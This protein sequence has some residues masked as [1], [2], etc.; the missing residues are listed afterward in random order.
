DLS[1]NNL[2]DIDPNAFRGLKKLRT[3][4]QSVEWRSNAS[5][6]LLNFLQNG[7]IGL[8]MTAGSILVAYLVTVDHEL[9]VEDYVLF[10]TYIL[11]LYFPLNFFG[12][13]YRTIQKSFI[14]ME[15]M[16]DLMNEEDDVSLSLYGIFDRFAPQY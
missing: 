2:R 14:D 5:L 1:K 4:F 3:I 11:Q 9:T 7:T 15:N 16:F 8:G 12:T 6:A 13:V 10:T